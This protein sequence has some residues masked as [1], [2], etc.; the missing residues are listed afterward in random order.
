MT[1]FFII[2]GV[3]FMIATLVTLTAGI[4]L[5]ASGGE[6]NRKYGT[7][8]MSMRVY[9]QALAIGCMLAAFGTAGN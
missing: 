9:M 6:T 3:F 7:K 5:M 8:L 2:A 4:A 1:M